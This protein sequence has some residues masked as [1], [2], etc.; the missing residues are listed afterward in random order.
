MY[1]ILEERID[2]YTKSDTRRRDA[3]QRKTYDEVFDHMALLRIYKLITSQVI[4]TLDHP[5]STGKEGNVY[6]ATSPDGTLLAVKIYRT[7]TATFRNIMKY[8][9]GN[10]RYRNI[11]HKRR[12]LIS[13]WAKKE[14]NNLS[15]LIKFKVS[16]P[17]PVHVSGNILV[18]EYIGNEFGAAP[19]LKDVPMEYPE[20]LYMNIIE[21]YFKIYNTA[22]LVHADL[23]EYNILLTEEGRLVL[24]DI[25]QCVVREHPE[26]EN[27]LLRDLK[28]IS[29]FFVRR[30]VAADWKNA[31]KYIKADNDKNK[32][33]I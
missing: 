5:I 28:N 2:G 29:R 14:Y 24:I 25:G 15:R 9:D 21:E 8:I 17:Q 31:L 30:G 27:W 13:V 1:D 23:S 33:S 3:D 20:E 16:V 12:Q 10:P 7:S 18:M 22:C 19:M 6:R 26:A 11:P 4:E 32:F